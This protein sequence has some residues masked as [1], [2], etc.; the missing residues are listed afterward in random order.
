[1]CCKSLSIWEAVTISILP[2][3]VLDCAVVTLVR[4]GARIS[5]CLGSWLESAKGETCMRFG[6]QTEAA[7]SVLRKSF[8]QSDTVVEGCREAQWV[9]ACPNSALLHIQSFPAHA[10]QAAERTN[11][12]CSIQRQSCSPFS[13]SLQK[14]DVLSF[15]D[16]PASSKLSTHANV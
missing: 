5:F 2:I 9:L 16:F 7:V 4:W 8:S 10:G 1:M 13:V 12:R 3:V 6:R 14:Q 11:P 15:L